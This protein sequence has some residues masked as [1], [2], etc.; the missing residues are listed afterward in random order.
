MQIRW[1]MTVRKLRVHAS[2]WLLIGVGACVSTAVAEETTAPSVSAPQRL[3]AADCKTLP[4]TKRCEQFWDGEFSRAKPYEHCQK[5]PEEDGCE[6][7]KIFNQARDSY[8]AKM[9]AQ[10]ELS[11]Y[12]QTNAAS[13]RC[14]ARKARSRVSSKR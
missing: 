4:Y 6:N 2:A 13:P 7:W 9:E 10:K 1:W 3:R 5:N 12:C 14:L 8:V 11:Q